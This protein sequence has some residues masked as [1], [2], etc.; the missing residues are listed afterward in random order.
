MALKQVEALESVAKGNG[1]QTILIPAA[2][3]EAFGNAFG[4]LK[5]KP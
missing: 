1:K 3:L 5:G 2:A 4:M